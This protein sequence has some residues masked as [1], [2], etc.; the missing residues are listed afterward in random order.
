MDWLGVS[1]WP[2]QS[3]PSWRAESFGLGWAPGPM[4]ELE[5]RKGTQSL[6]V[7]KPC[8]TD[9]H[10]FRYQS[11]QNGCLE[12]EKN[13]INELRGRELRCRA[14]SSWIPISSGSRSHVPLLGFPQGYFSIPTINYTAIL[15]MNSPLCTDHRMNF[16]HHLK[17]ISEHKHTVLTH[18]Y[19]LGH[20]CFPMLNTILAYRTH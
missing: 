15:I 1:T 10:V 8:V 17:W 7:L 2:K 9:S 3:T 11:K 4:W 6:L 20:F 14:L 16:C 5:L 13:E 19:C 12:K 18:I